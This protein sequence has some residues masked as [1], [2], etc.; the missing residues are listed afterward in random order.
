MNLTCRWTGS[1][2]R[3]CSDK[4][5]P[6]G[7]RRCLRCR[8]RAPRDRPNFGA[9][10]R[11][12]APRTTAGFR[13]PATCTAWPGKNSG[14]MAVASTCL[15]CRLQPCLKPPHSAGP[16]PGPFRVSPTPRDLFMPL[17]SCSHIKAPVHLL[18]DFHLGKF[19]DTW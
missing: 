5:G 2:H 17:D 9:S 8:T 13:L 6:R 11:V 4:R 3:C 14:L 10:Q 15:E 7:G 16:G 19:Y 1:G 18:E 12:Q